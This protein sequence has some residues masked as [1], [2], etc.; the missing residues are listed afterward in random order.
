M[1]LATVF[2]LSHWQKAAL[3]FV[4]PPNNHVDRFA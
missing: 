3:R 4:D 2:V 1:G